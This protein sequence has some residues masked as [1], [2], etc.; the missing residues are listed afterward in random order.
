VWWLCTG[1]VIGQ[2]SYT[3]LLLLLCMKGS[4]A[5]ERSWRNKGLRPR[6]ALTHRCARA[7]A[8]NNVHTHANIHVAHA[9]SHRRRRH[10]SR[11]L[12]GWIILGLPLIISLNGARVTPSPPI[13]YVITLSREHPN[14]RVSVFVAFVFVE[15]VRR[16]YQPLV[17][18]VR[19]DHPTS[20]R[21][22]EVGTFRKKIEE[23][24]YGE[25]THFATKKGKIKR[26]TGR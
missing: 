23:S 14:A 1:I 10:V 16:Y 24:R 12:P 3:R 9:A 5:V 17:Y 13:S 22:P 20:N 15:G 6:V 21:P 11:V 7:T 25:N 2:S 19:A 18:K 4:A 26:P 8:N